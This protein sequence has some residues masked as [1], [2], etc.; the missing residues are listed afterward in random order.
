M[1]INVE[2]LW[3]IDFQFLLNLGIPKKFAQLTFSNS[4]FWIISRVSFES[5]GRFI[6][7]IHNFGVLKL[8]I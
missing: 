7:K 4:L 6:I 8:K 5:R 3:F 2:F 1:K